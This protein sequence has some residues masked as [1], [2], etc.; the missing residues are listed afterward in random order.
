MEMIQVTYADGSVSKLTWKNQKNGF[1]ATSCDHYDENGYYLAKH[2][3]SRENVAFTE[4]E[5]AL[6][7]AQDLY[8]VDVF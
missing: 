5:R 7:A 6:E 3:Q 2:S 4:I 8:Q 1:Y